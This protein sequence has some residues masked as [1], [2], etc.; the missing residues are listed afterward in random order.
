MSD[1]ESKKRSRA[2]FAAE[3]DEEVSR[4]KKEDV[5]MHERHTSKRPR[6]NYPSNNNYTTPQQSDDDFTGL[7]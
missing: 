4:D 2:K 1:E 3:R 7:Y 6:K 5:V